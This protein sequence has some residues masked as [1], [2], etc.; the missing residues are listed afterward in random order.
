MGLF[1]LAY[2][3]YTNGP[4]IVSNNTGSQAPNALIM[5]GGTTADPI[6][7]TA[8]TASKSF[9]DWRF[10]D[11]ATSGTSRGVYV[12]L[13]LVAGAGGEAGRFRCTVENATPADTCNGAHNTLD[14]L[15]TGNITGLGTASRHTIMY[16]TGKTI[17]GTV[18]SIMAEAYAEGAAPAVS[19]GALIRCVL[20]GDA[21]GIGVLDHSLALI[22]VD[23]VSVDTS[24]IIQAKASA[25]VS[26]CARLLVNGVAYYMML[27][28]TL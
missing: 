5:G 8:L 14:F 27:S 19:Q 4:H 23:G 18:A 7:N 9:I 3:L 11:A 1:R 2:D 13:A 6:T 20:G 25:T 16:P 28:T 10:E 15:G 24:H 26:H 17:G 12:Q 21:T 22:R